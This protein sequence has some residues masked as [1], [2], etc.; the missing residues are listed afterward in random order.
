MTS[1]FDRIRARAAARKGGD[2]ALAA[3]LPPVPSDAVLRALP[4]D[5]VLAEM[6]R[7]IFCAGFV[8]SVIDAKWDGFEAVFAGFDP[9]R[10]S[11]EPDE[12]FERAA[13]DARIVRH[14]AKVMSV[15]AN[16]RFVMDI[17][18]EH[19]SFARFLADW[20]GTDLV[21]LWDVLNKRGARLGGASGQ[22]FLRFIGKD[23]FILN[24][25]VLAALR[26]EGLDVTTGAGKAERRRIQDRFNRWHD[27]TGLCLTHLSRICAM[28]VGENRAMSP[29]EGH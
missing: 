5:R 3:L 26:D 24:P 18:A 2:A 22:Y 27:E 28:S 4:D 13:S 7:R 19:G 25:D 16:A 23:C 11:F 17:A 1:S 6:T 9:A 21:G 12:F 14:A 20:P 29:G 15:Q 10:L 8:W